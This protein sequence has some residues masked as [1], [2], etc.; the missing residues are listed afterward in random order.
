MNKTC[1]FNYNGC[2]VVVKYRTRTACNEWFDIFIDQYTMTGPNCNPANFP[3]A[4]RAQI[5]QQVIQTFILADGCIVQPDLPDIGECRDNWR[6]S[7]GSCWQVQVGP[8]Q[9]NNQSLWLPCSNE[10]CCLDRYIICRNAQGVLSAT[11]TGGIPNACP[12][13]SVLPNYFSACGN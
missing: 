1:S 7:Y 8:Y 3:P 9:P 12:P 11:K 5:H 6:V 13:E 10:V 4:M 2:A